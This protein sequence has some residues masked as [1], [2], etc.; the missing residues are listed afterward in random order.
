[1]SR[2]V[3]AVLWGSTRATTYPKTIFQQ[4]LLWQ[5]RRLETLSGDRAII[6]PGSQ[7]G[8]PTPRLRYALLLQPLCST[9]CLPPPSGGPASP[10]E[11]GSRAPHL[12][13]PAALPRALV[14]RTRCRAGSP[15][16]RHRDTA[17]RSPR[18]ADLSRALSS[19]VRCRAGS[20]ATGTV[21]S[22]VVVS[23]IFSK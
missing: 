1:M 16:H 11:V 14:Q 6:L 4:H 12:I 7:P 9:R 19:T 15:P 22:R 23:S 5:L 10:S 2:S 18:R 20:R 13:E 17:L 3:R 8:T 21:D